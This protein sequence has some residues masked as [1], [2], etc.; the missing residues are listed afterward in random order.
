MTN[1]WVS[2]WTLL[3]IAVLFMGG[4]Q[5]L[6][7]GVLGEYIGRTYEQ[8]KQRPLYI[9]RAT[10]GF[11]SAEK[12]VASAITNMPKRSSPSASL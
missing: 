3:F 5:L 2:G 9:V 12:P 11:E 6:V 8:S 4:V 1:S 7:L 10:Q